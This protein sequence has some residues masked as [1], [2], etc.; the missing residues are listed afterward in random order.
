[1]L[2]QRDEMTVI[3]PMP[4]LKLRE[5]ES[6]AQGH[7]AGRTAVSIQLFDCREVFVALGHEC[8]NV[9]PLPWH[10]GPHVGSFIARTILLQTPHG[11]LPCLL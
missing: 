9:G 1:M 11:S 3:S 7:T 8:G 10:L 5:V 6:F 2:T 4:Q